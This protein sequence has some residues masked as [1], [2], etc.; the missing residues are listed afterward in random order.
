[1]SPQTWART[2]ERHPF[3]VEYLRIER[4]A[5]PGKPP[6]PPDESNKISMVSL[7]K[8]GLGLPKLSKVLKEK[9]EVKIT[10]SV[11]GDVCRLQQLPKTWTVIGKVAHFRSDPNFPYFGVEITSVT[12]PSE[13]GRAE[14]D[15]FILWLSGSPAAPN[16]HEKEVLETKGVICNAFGVCCG[17]TAL[18]IPN[19]WQSVQMSLIGIMIASILVY[20][21]FR[22]KRGQ[23]EKKEKEAWQLTYGW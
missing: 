21:Y 4:I 12:D 19:L 11:M 1:M 14:L 15:R 17:I 16:P 23:I 22:F 7:S 5:G 8:H 2:R 9:E 10:F 3:E 20:M 13:N 18:V 6:E